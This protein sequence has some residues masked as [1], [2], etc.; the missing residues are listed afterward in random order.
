MLLPGAFDAAQAANAIGEYRPTTAFAAPTHLQRIMRVP[1]VPTSSFRLLAHAGAA[2]PVDLKRRIHEWVGVDNTWEFYGSTEGQFTTCPGREWLDRPGTLGRARPGRRIFID[3]G[4]IWCEA[5]SSSAFEYWNDPAKTDAAWR[6]LPSGARAFSVGD[7]G[8]L[9]DDGY[10]WMD[11]RRADLII[12]GG[13][14]VYP[15]Q[16]EEVI[17]EVPGVSES[18]VF[19]I[20]DA[21]WGQVVCVAYVGDVMPD[22]LLLAARPHLAKF[23]LPKHAFR[24]EELPRTP[25]GK[26]KRRDL[27]AILGLE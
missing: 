20:E 7:L 10:L 3:D 15:I 25:F 23:Q 14:N 17:T 12:T 18:A 27:P 6:T 22:E 1:D 9:D 16:V 2:C 21:E 5:P 11:G 24:I 13:V 19:G 8:H 4:V 26:V